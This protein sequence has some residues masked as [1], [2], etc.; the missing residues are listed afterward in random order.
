[1]FGFGIGASI[2]W[3]IILLSRSVARSADKVPHRATVLL[4]LGEMTTIAVLFVACDLVAPALFR[5]D[6]DWQSASCPVPGYEAMGSVAIC[7][8]LANAT[9]CERHPFVD[10]PSTL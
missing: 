5:S 8:E 1:M 10:I 6:V 7:L 9:I 3:F 4:H 2:V